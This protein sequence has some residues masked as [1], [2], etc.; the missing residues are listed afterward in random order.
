VVAVME[1]AVAV[2][3]A[4]L[5]ARWAVAAT[6]AGALVAARVEA[7]EAEVA[8]EVDTWPAASDAATSAAG[9]VLP[10]PM[11]TED[12][13]TTTLP[14]IRMT[15]RIRGGCGTATSAEARA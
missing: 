10:C 8:S 7:L 15:M 1:A 14:A 5:E 2:V 3:V 11:D 12:T 6:S 13:M 4:T 9:V